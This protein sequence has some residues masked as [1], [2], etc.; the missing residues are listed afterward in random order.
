MSTSSFRFQ[1]FEVYHDRCGMKVGTDGVLLASWV[2][3]GSAQQI[4]DVGTGSGLMALI[5]AQ[6]SHAEVLGVEVDSSAARQA[7]ENAANSP[8]SSRIRILEADVRHFSGESFDLIVS[9]PPFF[10]QS[11]HAPDAAR[12]Q[13]RHNVG[14]SYRDLVSKASGLLKQE[15]RFA[16]ILPFNVK[17]E[18]EDLCWETNLFLSRSCQV[19]TVEGK[20]PKRILLEFSRARCSIQHS[21]I[22]LSM[23]NGSRSE[24]YRQLTSDLYLKP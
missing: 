6:R 2:E 10:Q 18:F 15:G 4:L 20:S 5:L 1:Q 24:A 17:H 11:L 9:N 14:L 12:N 21:A 22:S 16:V 8:F 7:T 13:A 19:T 3:T 23:P